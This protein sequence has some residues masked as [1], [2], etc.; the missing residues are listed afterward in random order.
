VD[1]IGGQGS[2]V[3]WSD[4][5]IVVTVPAGAVSGYLNVYASGVFSNNVPFTVGP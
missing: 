2:V 3:S 1:F 4:T 5:S